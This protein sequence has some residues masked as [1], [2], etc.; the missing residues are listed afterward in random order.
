MATM[1]LV[2]PRKTNAT[3]R[4]AG[5]VGRAASV[6]RVLRQRVETLMLE[7]FAFMD[8]PIFKQRNIEKELFDFD[9]EPELPL[10]SWY[11]PT[12][13]EASEGAVQLQQ[14]AAVKGQKDH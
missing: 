5:S 12:R 7:N 13:D 1:T 11:Q 10:T 9:H 2:S 6:P 14:D 3:A 4:K 8:S